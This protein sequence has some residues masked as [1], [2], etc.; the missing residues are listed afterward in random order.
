MMARV[1]W[2]ACC[3]RGVRHRFSHTASQP[4]EGRERERIGARCLTQQ[5]RGHMHVM[6]P[7]S[8]HSAHD[9]YGRHT[10]AEKQHTYPLRRRLRAWRSRAGPASLNLSGLH[11]AMCSIGVGTPNLMVAGRSGP[12][13]PWFLFGLSRPA[14]RSGLVKELARGVSKGREIAIRGPTRRFVV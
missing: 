11:H 10:G 7:W 6:M 5:I 4:T 2:R 9:R 13:Q 12:R 14:R 1:T 8:R 3:K